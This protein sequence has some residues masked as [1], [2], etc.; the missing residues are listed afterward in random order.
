MLKPLWARVLK[1]VLKRFTS[2][3]YAGAL[4]LGVNGIVV[5]THG[6]SDEIAFLAAMNYLIEQ[7]RVVDL[8]LLRAEL[9]RLDPANH[10]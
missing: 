10:P 8:N 1:G 6:K 7:L 4:L 9:V 5:K 2:T 3:R